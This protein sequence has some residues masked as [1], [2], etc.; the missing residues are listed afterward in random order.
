MLVCPAV[1]SILADVL[2]LPFLSSFNL[3]AV[4]GEQLELQSSTADI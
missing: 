1:S 3:L 2:L 4:G